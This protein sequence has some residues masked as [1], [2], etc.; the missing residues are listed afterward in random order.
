MKSNK[1]LN[2]SALRKCLSSHFR[3]IPD[4]RQTAKIN[5]SIHD[6]MMCGFACMY[7]QDPSLLQFQKQLKDEQNRNNLTTLFDVDVIPENT[8][9]R[10]LVDVVPSEQFRPIFKNY[11][12]ALQRSKYLEHYQFLPGLYLCSIDGTQ[13]FN[14]GKV[15]CKKC[16]KTRHKNGEVTSSHKVL[17]AAIMHPDMRQVI[18]LM[19]E[20]I[21]NTDGTEKQDCESNAGKRLLPKIRTDHPQLGLIIVGDDLFSR[22]PFIESTLNEGMHYIFVA[23]ESSHAVMFNAI[24]QNP[25]KLNVSRFVDEKNRTHV[26]EWMNGVPLNG[27][28]DTLMTNFF[29]YTILITDKNGNEKIT[30]RASWISD[31]D[32]SGKLIKH[33]VRGGRCRWKIENECFNTL[34]NQGYHIEHNYGHGK[35]NLCFNFLLLTLLAFFFH[36]IFEL[37][38]L[39]YQACRKKFG[40]KKHLWE[41]LRSYIRILIFETWEILLDFALTPTK[42]NLPRYARC[43]PP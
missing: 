16:L 36:Q 15:D 9:L 19:P 38:D 32:L 42:Y 2:F 5:Y 22:Q 40:S 1:Q 21:R 13:F 28:K 20:E 41:T 12:C 31:L 30:F 35:E 43:R 8:Q 25:E 6:A 10:D 14:S 23:K 37:T 24:K 29:R 11:F 27:N 33:F 17:Q 4:Q 34:K 18:P 39:L 26:Y 7:F 3:Q